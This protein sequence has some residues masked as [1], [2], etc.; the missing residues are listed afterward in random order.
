MGT[1]KDEFTPFAADLGIG[2]EGATFDGVEHEVIVR[3][4]AFGDALEKIDPSPQLT[5]TPV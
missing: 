5:S 3:H 2:H 1:L 4:L